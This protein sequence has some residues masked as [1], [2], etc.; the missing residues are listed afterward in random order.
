MYVCMYVYIYTYVFHVFCSH[1]ATDLYFGANIT[2]K[3][4]LSVCFLFFTQ[5]NKP[6]PY[7]WEEVDVGGYPVL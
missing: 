3:E 7:L 2:P 4:V 6:I 1:I 5:I